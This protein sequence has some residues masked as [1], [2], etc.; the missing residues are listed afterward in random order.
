MITTNI[1]RFAAITGL[2]LLCQ[3]SEQSQQANSGRIAAPSSNAAKISDPSGPSLLQERG[4]KLAIGEY[5]LLVTGNTLFRPLA[6][7]G[8]T[9]I[10]IAP[11]GDQKMLLRTA[12]G[13]SGT[14][15]GH[16][17][18]RGSLACWQWQKAGAGRILCFQPYWNGRVLTMVE[19][20]GAVQPAQFVVQKGNSA[21]L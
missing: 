10:Y 20:S 11:D 1:W 19:T 21:S 13:R 3:C 8:E 14:D 6:S 17:T 7:G 9:A 12:D 15:N 4:S 5:R 2:F 18:E 16:Q